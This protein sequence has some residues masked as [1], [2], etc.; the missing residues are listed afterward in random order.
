MASEGGFKI[1]VEGH[2]GGVA[3]EARAD[4]REHPD[5]APAPHKASEPTPPSPPREV[6]KEPEVVKA[7]ADDPLLSGTRYSRRSVTGTWLV[8]ISAEGEGASVTPDME[9]AFLTAL[10]EVGATVSTVSE[11]TSACHYSAEV[12]VHADGVLTAVLNGISHFQA[13]AGVARLPAI[14]IVSINARDA[15][16][17]G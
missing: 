5:P 10:R 4:L 2:G 7:P 16:A 3:G 13:A 9:H 1:H 8:A 6:V 14:R 12:S 15:E 11:S 17:T